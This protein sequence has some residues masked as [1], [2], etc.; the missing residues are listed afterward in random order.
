MLTPATCR[1][2]RGLVSISQAALAAA[3]GVGLS[4][5]KNY[6]AGRSMPV[7]NNLAAIGRVLEDAGVVFVAAGE[8]SLEGGAGVRLRRPLHD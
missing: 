2:A 1:A 7:T 6:E 8:A 5:V 3:A 4:T